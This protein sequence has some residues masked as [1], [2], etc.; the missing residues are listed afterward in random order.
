[1][2]ASTI[3]RLA[4]ANVLVVG[5]VLLDRFV[6]GSVARISREAPVPVLGAGRSDAHPGGACNVAANVL[7]CGGKATLIGI[8]GD[9]AAGAELT[10]ICASRTGMS[11][12]MVPD[13]ARSTTVKTRYLSGWQQLLCVDTEDRRPAPA[14]IARQLIEKA[15]AALP[16]AGAL[17]LS[18]YGRG[19]LDRATI[20]TLIGDARAA[21]VPVVVD[22]R[23]DDPA[24]YSGATL[25]T[26]NL[27]E[28]E[29]FT[30]IYADTD[31]AAVAA[32]RRVIE[33]ADVDAV[34]LTRG[35]D[36]MTLV[37][38]GVPDDVVHV[39]AETQQVFDV[40]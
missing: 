11:V 19:A 12:H 2:D 21:G 20:A 25:V 1:M 18:D 23:H 33:E 22:P 39:H 13:P 40:T 9:D 34:L 15:R 6:Q 36:G 28:M 26:P 37:R 16:D 27:G 31:A 38:R 17:V 3:D 8:V 4:L 10:E 32:C 30:G 35:A 14:A 24:V 5:D 29:R 7:S